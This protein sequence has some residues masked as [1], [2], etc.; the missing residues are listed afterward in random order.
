MT[1]FDPQTPLLI[2]ALEDEL[3][4]DMTVGWTITYTG[5][6]RVNAAFT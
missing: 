2:V 1:S 4:R 6:C 5:V 3:Q